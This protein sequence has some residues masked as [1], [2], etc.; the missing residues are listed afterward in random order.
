MNPERRSRPT[1]FSA[2][3][4]RSA[5]LAEAANRGIPLPEAM[6]QSRHSSV[7]QPPT[8]TTLPCGAADEHQGRFDTDHAQKALTRL[9]LFSAG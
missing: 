6:E 5:C 3:G 1:A 4:L 9:L 2:H 8:I 7:Q